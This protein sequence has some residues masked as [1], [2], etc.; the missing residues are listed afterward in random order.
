VLL[1]MNLSLRKPGMK[2]LARGWG[3]AVLFFGAVL[4]HGAS[5]KD[6]NS[7]ADVAS[8]S[9][10]RVRQG[11]TLDLH[12][13]SSALVIVAL[14]RGVLNVEGSRLALERGDYKMWEQGA[15]I[16]V[17]NVDA[18]PAELAIVKMKTIGDQRL[19]VERTKLD[20]KQVLEDA[21]DRNVTLVLALERVSLQDERSKNDGDER[22]VKGYSHRIDLNAG[23]TGW[24][25]AGSHHLKNIGAG[26]ADFLTI[27]Q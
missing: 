20:R 16:R 2:G 8:N 26:S 14:S 7:Y 1:S 3:L 23:Q 27:E 5:A 6:Q 19:T 10:V 22:W 9:I 12:A 15:E 21:S 4:T 11:E 17:T 24:M 18:S 13:G 25:S